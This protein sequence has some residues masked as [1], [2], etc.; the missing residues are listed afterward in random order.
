MG[1]EKKKM[2]KRTV[3][4]ISLFLALLMLPTLMI[5][6]EAA[7]KKQKRFAFHS[8]VKGPGMIAWGIAS[9]PT[10]HWGE[11]EYDDVFDDS[12]VNFAGV[13][14]AQEESA[15]YPAVKMLRLLDI[16]LD[17]AELTMVWT[18]EGTRYEL[19]LRLLSTSDT[20]G[21]Y[22]L[23]WWPRQG[24]GG[25]VYDTLG[26]VLYIGVDLD[27]VTEEMFNPEHSTLQFVGTYK[28]N[29]V[30]QTISGNAWIGMDEF[31]GTGFYGKAVGLYLWI[32]ELEEYVTLGW[33]SNEKVG[34]PGTEQVPPAQVLNIYMKE[35][36]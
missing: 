24:D 6:A 1:G 26:E 23:A 18:Y 4:I 11:L 30:K 13:S 29:E 5:P 16:R 32:N 7:A 17:K 15:E 12:E 8:V 27:Y 36:K 28:V 14:D 22:G 10:I 20:D 9:L 34:I 21:M 35:K 19:R 3:W 31:F 2:N 25:L 33:V